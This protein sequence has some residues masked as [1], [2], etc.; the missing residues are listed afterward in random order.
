[1]NNFRFEASVTEEEGK[2]EIAGKLKLA[3]QAIKA[4]GEENRFAEETS[5]EFFGDYSGMRPPLN[6]AQAKETMI[7]IE[8][9]NVPLDVPIHVTLTPLSFLTS[10]PV[11]TVA[12][13]GAG[14]VNEA[15][16]LLKDIEDIQVSLD[17]LKNSATSRNLRMSIEKITQIYQTKEIMLKSKLCHL[18]YII[19]GDGADDR[20]L[21]FVIREYNESLFGKEK[22]YDWFHDLQ[23]E[24]I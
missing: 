15:L 24:V 13:L 19:K 22:T 9:D 18:L 16:H 2:D 14:P 6:L 7:G 8:G 20:E 17:A 11:K 23:D 21:E 1:M 10:N 5:C 12:T 4:E 3:I